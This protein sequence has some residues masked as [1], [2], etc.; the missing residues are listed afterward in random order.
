MNYRHLI[1]ILVFIA[2]Q[3]LV[4]A[5]MFNDNWQT[6]R[7]YKA[8]RSYRVTINN[9]YG[10]V[11][12][13]TWNKDS[14]RISVTRGISEKSP[15][16]LKR[17]VESIDIRFRESQGQVMVETFVGSRHTTFIQD[18]K[19]AG[20]FSTAGPRTKID[21]IIMV[22]AHVHL[23]IT[24][25]YGDVVL[26]DLTGHVKVDLSNGNIQGR[27][28]SGLAEM[29]LAFGNAEFRSIRQ[30]TFF[31]NFVNFSCNEA[32]LLT[33]DS[34]SSEIKVKDVDHFKISSRRDRIALNNARFL[35]AET[36]FSNIN[37][38]NLEEY[39][40][41][42]LTYGRLENLSLASS[43]KGCDIVSQTCDVYL[44]L[45]APAPYSALI[46]ANKLINLPD[47]LKSE[48]PDFRKVIDKE[49]VR[50]IFRRKMPEDKLKINISDGELKI[51]HR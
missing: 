47:D 12:V 41:L 5:Q 40:S 26:P 32:E 44:G 31:L 28:L 11:M 18:V 19:E 10:S 7:T 4:G 51:D 16:R 6:Q 29:N 21:Y 20:N 37:C 46:K 3:H 15:E 38:Y 27:D 45:V 23:D 33:M 22:P 8:S 9:K 25:K 35:E 13:S 14:V 50:F 43:F 2:M 17:L 42:K 39:G 48:M 30:G 1:L 49:P 36:Y 34:R 24:N